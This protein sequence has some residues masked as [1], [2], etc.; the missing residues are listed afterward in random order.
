[1]G[2]RRK[3]LQVAVGERIRLQRLS[4][5]LSVAEL[6]LIIDVSEGEL[7]AYEQGDKRI[8]SSLLLD[9]CRST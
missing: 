2:E 6:A 3:S 9:P 5:G 7:V 4:Q 1:M 8:F